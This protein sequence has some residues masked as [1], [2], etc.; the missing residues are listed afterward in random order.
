M[1]ALGD[2]HG[3]GA[4]AFARAF[5][6]HLRL[7]SQWRVRALG[8][9]LAVA[10][11]GLRLGDALQ[12]HF[13]VRRPRGAS[14]VDDLRRNGTNL[15]ILTAHQPHQPHLA[16]AGPPVPAADTPPAAMTAHPSQG[17]TLRGSAELLDDGG[18]LLVVSPM[19]DTLEALQAFGLNFGH[20]ARHDGVA[21]LLLMARTTHIAARD[22]QR[23][24]QSLQAR[25]AQLNTILELS[26]NG[27][28]AFDAGGA[29]L[30]TNAALRS[31]L[32]LADTQTIGLT[33][34]EVE[35]QLQS[36]CDPA[37]AL[38]PVFVDT[39]EEQPAQRELTLVVPRPTVLR[40]SSRRTPEGGRVFYLQDVTADS[41]IDR[42]KSEFLTTA[43]HELRTPMVSVYGFT[44][45][46]LHRPVS[47]ERRR[48][49]LQTIHR[50]AGLLVTM[51][52][53]LLD[54]ARIEARQ[55][56]DLN[57]VT[58]AL[59]PMIRLAVAAHAARDDGRSVELNLQH[60]EHQ[61]CVDAEKF[62]SALGNVLGNA[63]KYSPAGGAVALD[64]LLGECASRPAI[65]LR[66]RDQGIGMSA[67]ELARVFERFYRADPSGHIPGTGLGMSLVREILT[68]HGGQV[69]IDSAPG[70]GTTVTL[71]W[72]LADAAAQPVA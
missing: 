5:P 31:M 23:L 60:G 40:V 18:V 14:T 66:V 24:A 68:L 26:Q 42:M 69:E 39:P 33:L 9:S 28:A 2:H 32:Q 19:V 46:L 72:P 59:G 57:R 41:E 20:F 71:W 6:F 48:D 4:A 43:A 55:G 44:E 15:V 34:D 53:E 63:F 58:Q 35:R 62:N 13:T 11:P 37:V 67:D 16:S 45:L 30:H 8:A 12:A 36:L 56:K 22:T 49:M 3:L 38:A 1:N 25:T 17:L 52:N 65:G 50:Q 7:D 47:D 61:V 64:T 27:V 51:V 70:Q 54:L 21:D 10:V 29:L